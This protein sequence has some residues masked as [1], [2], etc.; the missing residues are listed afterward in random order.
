MNPSD[1]AFV[2]VSQDDL[3][4]ACVSAMSAG[5]IDNQG[6]WLLGDACVLGS[7]CPGTPDARRSFLKSMYFATDVTT[8]TMG[9]SQTF[10]ASKK[11]VAEAAVTAV[12]PKK[13]KKTPKARRGLPAGHRRMVKQRL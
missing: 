3:T 7:G 2:P 9:L 4:G 11:T 8:N 1:L 6:S 5:D 12:A 13:A 10:V